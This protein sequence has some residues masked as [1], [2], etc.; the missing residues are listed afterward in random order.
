MVFFLI[1]KFLDDGVRR[2]LTSEDIKDFNP[3]HSK[4]FNDEQEYQAKWQKS[5]IHS[6]G[7][8]PAKILCM[9]GKIV[10]KNYFVKFFL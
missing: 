10:V 3:R 2:V 1:V 8:W 9:A 7:F 4:E 5:D 6:D